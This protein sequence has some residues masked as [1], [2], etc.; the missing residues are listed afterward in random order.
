[1]DPGGHIKTWSHPSLFRIGYNRR[2]CA[3]THRCIYVCIYST[4]IL[5]VYILSTVYISV[6]TLREGST[7]YY[8]W[9]WMSVALA[10]IWEIDKTD[11][12]IRP[13]GHAN[14][15][16]WTDKYIL[17]G[18]T[19]VDTCDNWLIVTVVSR[20]FYHYEILMINFL[21]SMQ[22]SL[23]CDVADDKLITPIVQV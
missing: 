2:V 21:L 3:A 12:L 10:N 18:L 13:N 4:C 15:N 11:K 9:T 6:Y 7:K 20:S 22:L 14:T 19:R 5:C 16:T 8:Y 17:K 1:M 23:F